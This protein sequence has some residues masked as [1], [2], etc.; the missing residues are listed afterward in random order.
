MPA[1][2]GVVAKEGQV[3]AGWAEEVRAVEVQG[4]LAEVKEAEEALAAAE[5]AAAGLD[6][7]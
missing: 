7:R 3:A 5:E 1:A 6:T 4:A 2:E